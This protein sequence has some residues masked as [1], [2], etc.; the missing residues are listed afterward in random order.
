MTFKLSDDKAL[1]EETFRSVGRDEW[2][3]ICKSVKRVEQEMIELEHI[4]DAV[5]YTHLDVYKR[6]V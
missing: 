6:Q 1:A 5:S 2:N 3:N 4:V